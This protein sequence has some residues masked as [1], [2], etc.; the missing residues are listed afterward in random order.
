MANRRLRYDLTL[1][2]CIFIMLLW[3]W[4]LLGIIYSAKGIQMNKHLAKIVI[5]HPHSIN[6]FVTLFASV[7]CLLIDIIFSFAVIR[8][9]QEWIANSDNITV[10]DVS[11]ISGLRHQTLPWNVKEIKQL[12]VGN[13]V[14]PVSLVAICIGAFALI[15]S[16][17]TSLITPVPFKKNV[18]LHGV[19]LDFSSSAADCLD[20]LEN[21]KKPD[22]NFG[23]SYTLYRSKW[24]VNYCSAS[25]RIISVVSRISWSMS[26]IPVAVT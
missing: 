18:T 13:R 15:P 10:F 21:I 4:I 22:C 24:F 11:V 12:L 7:V 26:L 6:F 23:V 20:W 9:S 14:A 19:E 1:L 8:F 17:I 25:R 2:S 16:G 3:P 5:N